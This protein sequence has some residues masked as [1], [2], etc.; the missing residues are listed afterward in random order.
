MVKNVK[1]NKK[2]LLAIL[3]FFAFI[4]V[5]GYTGA[6]YAASSNGSTGQDQNAGREILD[7]FSLNFVF[8]STQDE[9]ERPPI[10]ITTRPELRS[11]YRPPLVF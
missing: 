8:L 1:K 7:P 11:Y 3:M 4:A 9:C 10:R 2:I 6:V 5:A